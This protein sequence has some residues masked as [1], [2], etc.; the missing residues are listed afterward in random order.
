MQSLMLVYENF[1][2][3]FI[4]INALVHIVWLVGTIQ[5]MALL[6]LLDSKGYVHQSIQAH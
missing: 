3:H 1:P 5:P 2:F 4:D 6:N